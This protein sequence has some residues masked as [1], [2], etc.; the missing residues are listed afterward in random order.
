VKTPARTAAGTSAAASTA[1]WPRRTPPPRS[2]RVRATAPGRPLVEGAIRHHAGAR[3]DR[4]SEP[5][6]PRKTGCCG[7]AERTNGQK[8]WTAGT[9]RSQAGGPAGPAG[10]PPE[11]LP[12]R[13]VTGSSPAVFLPGPSPPIHP[14][15]ASPPRWPSSHRRTRRRAAGPARDPRAPTAPRP[16]WQPVEKVLRTFFH[17]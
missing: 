10:K 16:G 5:L 15:P 9:R 6:V 12:V 13:L 3:S 1:K 8:G 17:G 11:I 4:L 14:A 2:D 7:P